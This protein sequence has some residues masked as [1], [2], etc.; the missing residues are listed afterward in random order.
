MV[1]KT[2]MERPIWGLDEKI[3]PPRKYM[4]YQYYRSEKVWRRYE[5]AVLPV[6]DWNFRWLA[7]EGTVLRENEL[8]VLSI[9]DRYYR[10]KTVATDGWRKEAQFGVNEL[11]VRDWYYRWRPVLPVEPDRYYR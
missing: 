4:N 5:L 1:K 3:M 2:Y 9:R 7:E 8:P 6:R 11:P 10:S